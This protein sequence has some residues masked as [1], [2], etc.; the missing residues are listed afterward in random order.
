LLVAVTKDLPT[1]YRP[2]QDKSPVHIFWRKKYLS[3]RDVREKEAGLKGV[4]ELVA[5]LG[6]GTADPSDKIQI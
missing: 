5:N 6:N 4:E 2:T 3:D 1:F